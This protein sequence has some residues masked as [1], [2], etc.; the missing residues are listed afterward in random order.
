MKT[1]IF[2]FTFLM[3]TSVLAQLE[4]GFILNPR[5]IRINKNDPKLLE[6][7]G[8]FLSDSATKVKPL[9]T[10]NK[11]ISNSGRGIYMF[12]KIGQTLV[13]GVPKNFPEEITEAKF[14]SEYDA[15]AVKT[16]MGVDGTAESRTNCK[17][18]MS[19]GALWGKSGRKLSCYTA[20]PGLCSR[21]EKVKSQLKSVDFNKLSKE[22][23]S[24]ATTIR[25]LSTISSDLNEYV[26][27][28]EYRDL[29]VKEA[30]NM[31]A[32]IDS[33]QSEFKLAP[34]DGPFQPDDLVFFNGGSLKGTLDLGDLAI[35]LERISEA[36]VACAGLENANSTVSSILGK[37]TTSTSPAVALPPD[38][39]VGAPARK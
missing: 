21:L 10:W 35:S 19:Q 2:A 11:E 16:K 34:V 4:G 3:A 20:N 22:L 1:I 27:N 14:N 9:S 7:Y 29:A 17:V 8:S 31:K 36:S 37:N 28:K 15:I 26:R 33:K 38:Q 25:S 6:T 32:F 24:C 30:K 12:S 5:E 23:D 13:N 39:A 18:S